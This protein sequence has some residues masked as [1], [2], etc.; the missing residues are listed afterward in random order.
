M[1]PELIGRLLEDGAV[2]TDPDEVW[3]AAADELRQLGL[4]EVEVH[5]FVRCADPEDEDFA[6]TNR[7]CTGRIYVTGGEDERCCPECERSVWPEAD[8]KRRHR[9]LR[10][11]VSRPGVLSLVQSQLADAFGQD[12]GCFSLDDWRTPVKHA[13]PASTAEFL[14]IRQANPGDPARQSTQHRM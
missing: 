12:G 8:R 7:Y 5:A 2:L 1:R 13:Q 3:V 10:M 4:V 14:I 11:V 9:E 6:L